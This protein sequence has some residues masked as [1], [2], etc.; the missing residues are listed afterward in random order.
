[1]EYYSSLPKRQRRER[2]TAAADEVVS[3]LAVPATTVTKDDPT[4]S[5]DDEDEMLGQLIYN[6]SR[7]AQLRREQ[8]QQR[9]DNAKEEEV[10]KKKR[11]YKSFEQR[12]DE[13]R[14]YKEK[15]GHTNVKEKEDKSLYEYCSSMRRARKH[16]E[17]SKTII[18]DDRIASLNALGFNWSVKEHVAKKSFKQRIEDLREYKEKH[19]HINVRKSDDKSLYDFCRKMRQSRKH[20]EKA[21]MLINDERRASLDT[22][23]FEWKLNSDTKSFEQRIVDLRAYKE[24]HGHTNVK[25]SEDKSLYQFCTNMRQAHDNPEK[26][27]RNLTDDR[28]ASLDASGFNWSAGRGEKAAQKSFAQR[29]KD[30]QPYKEKYGHVNV[31]PK[32]DTVFCILRPHEMCT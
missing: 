32:E 7:T 17:K 23:G 18:T 26:S 22:L 27:N 16:P 13:L 19:G 15:H 6:S 3:S 24:K 29:T 9:Q 11:I 8:Q 14:A 25:K 21:S 20:P 12:M 30:L 2:D 5:S 31:G 4:S 1:M 10:H 28:I